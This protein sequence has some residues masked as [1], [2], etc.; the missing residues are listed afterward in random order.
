MVAM[1]TAMAGRPMSLRSM[2]RS[3]AKPKTIMQTRPSA[4]ASHSGAPQAP[5]LP[6]TTRPAIMTNSP[7]AK[8]MASVAL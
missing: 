1:T 8:L 2:T 6:A 7:C 3:R 5:R 4:T